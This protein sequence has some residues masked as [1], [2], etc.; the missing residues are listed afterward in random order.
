M[1]SG[2]TTGDVSLV[3]R[4]LQHRDEHTL[5][6][7]V[8]LNL[9]QVARHDK[10]DGSIGGEEALQLTRARLADRDVLEL[11]DWPKVVIRDRAIR[12]RLEHVLF[13]HY[14]ATR[15][16]APS[17]VSV[18]LFGIAAGV[19]LI[20]LSRTPDAEERRGHYFEDPVK[21]IV[22]ALRHDVAI[23]GNLRCTHPNRGY[24]RRQE[25]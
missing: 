14:R 7:K 23:F 5:V 1:R 15:A 21:Q 20:A 10:R 2:S 11:I 12:D 18:R 9:G 17:L 24:G 13:E 4:P 25:L 22:V 8:L 6:G 19:A 3:Y 16:L